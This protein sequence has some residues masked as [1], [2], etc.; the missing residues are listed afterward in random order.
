MNRVQWLFSSNKTNLVLMSC[1]N[2]VEICRTF[3][4]KFPV[5]YVVVIFKCGFVVGDE[6]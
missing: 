3:L 6:I 4:V 5:N 1:G 2:S